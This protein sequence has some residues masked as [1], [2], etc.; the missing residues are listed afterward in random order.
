VGSRPVAAGGRRVYLWFGDTDGA[1]KVSVNRTH[2]P[3]VD[4]K[5]KASGDEA[6][7]YCR[8]FS[9]DVTAAVKPGGR[10]AAAVLWTWTSFNVLGTGGL[11]APAVF[12]ADKGDGNP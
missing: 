8:P 5:G 9:F 3:Y 7:G 2:V 1:A 4:P 11:L 10:N 6:R 12:Y